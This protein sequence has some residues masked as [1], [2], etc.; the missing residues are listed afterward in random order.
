MISVAKAAFH[1]HHHGLRKSLLFFS[2]LLFSSLCSVALSALSSV[3]P[4]GCP[5][6]YSQA[7]ESFT[8]IGLT[9]YV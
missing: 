7:K 9:S 1:L 4:H 6:R 8:D 2:S 5:T 3:H